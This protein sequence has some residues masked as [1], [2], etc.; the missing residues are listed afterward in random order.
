[1]NRF[2]ILLAALVLTLVPTAAFGSGFVG[3]GGGGGGAPSGPAGGDLGATFPNPTVTSVGNVTAG[4]LPAANGGSGVATVSS[5][6]FLGAALGSSGAPVFRTLSAPDLG[7]IPWTGDTRGTGTAQTVWAIQ[8]RN[9]AT[10]APTDG[11]FYAWSAAMSLWTPAT[12]SSGGSYPIAPSSGTATATGSQAFAVGDASVA[13]ADDAQAFG[14]NAHAAGILATSCG[15]GASAAGLAAVALGENAQ[16]G[17]DRSI[18][19]GGSAASPFAESV[20]IGF[21][22]ATTATNQFVVGADSSGMGHITDVY[23]GAGV[24]GSVPWT[25][26]GTTGAT[27]FG[28]GIQLGAPTGGD[29]GVGTI[30]VT[31][32]FYVNG[33]AVGGGGG[34]GTLNDA[35]TAGNVTGGKDLLITT[36]DSILPVSDTNGSIGSA[37]KRVGSIVGW[38]VACKSSAGVTFRVNVDSDTTGNRLQ[39]QGGGD[40]EF[41]PGGT[42][43]CDVGLKRST[44]GTIAVTNAAG[45]TGSIVPLGDVTGGTCGTGSKRWDSVWGANLTGR[46]SG[47]AA[48]VSAMVDGDTVGRVELWPDASVRF[49]PGGSSACNVGFKYVSTGTLYCT[50]GST[51]TGSIIPQGDVAGTNGSLGTGSKRWVEVWSKTLFGRNDGS[52]ATFMAEADGDSNYRVSLWP[53]GSVRFG[54]GSGT[55]AP[56]KVTCSA[57]TTGSSTVLWTNA[58]GTTVEYVP[59]VV[60]GVSGYIPFIH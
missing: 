31:G 39:I 27:T 9:V 8:G 49:G 7:G 35:L 38:L 5:D 12:P 10:T 37:S 19:I 44:T 45:G 58:P 23:F 17:G 57:V 11:Q 48:A 59:A 28:P 2:R 60:N 30:N 54:N 43:A 22:S 1:M 41:G 56:M 32:G 6:K 52:A 24:G 46:N 40:V 16:S 36:G 25:L 51:G 47:G 53:D 3:G 14:V 33:V 55:A 26:H 21:A 50:D 13:G 42:S 34:S 4:V 29:K 20:A 18:A 15:F